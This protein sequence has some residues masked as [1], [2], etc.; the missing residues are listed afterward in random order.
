MA[1]SSLAYVQH[2]DE[3]HPGAIE[4]WAAS[5]DLALHGFRADHGELPDLREGTPFVLLGGPFGARDQAPA[6]LVDERQWIGDALARGCPVLAV[7]LGAQLVADRLGA[8]VVRL[9]QGEMGWLEVELLDADLPRKTRVLEWHEDGFT[10][11]EGASCIA[12][13][14]ACPVQGY[15]LRERV[16]G[17][18]FHA[19]WTPSIVAALLRRFSEI[20]ASPFGPP[21]AQAYA[22]MYALFTRIL[23]RW[24]ASW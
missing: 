11:P 5:R 8:E 24:C 22:S 17:L 7:C 20:D 14:A 13:S 9:P 18:Q 23:D 21:D 19:E 16:V 3:E 12:R 10:L 1:R 15:R 6:W 4:A 2:L